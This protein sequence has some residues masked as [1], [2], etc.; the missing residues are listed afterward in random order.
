MATA[1]TARELRAAGLEVEA[2][3][4][5]YEG[6]P[7]VVDAIV[8]GRVQM[9]INSTDGRQKILDSASIRSEAI[10]LGIPCYTTLWAGRAV[11]EALNPE[12]ESRSVRKIQQLHQGF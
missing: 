5:V 6:S 4:K 11:A 7:H 3:R 12:T 8:N 9:V 2:V 10:R 1:G